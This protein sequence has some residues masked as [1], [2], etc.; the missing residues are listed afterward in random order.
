MAVDVVAVRVGIAGEIEP[1]HGH[2][3]AVA[4][5]LQQ[6]VDALFVSVGRFIGQES[7][8]FGDGGRQAG[9]VISDAAEERGFVG[10][11][12][13]LQAF[14]V[15]AGEDE[16]IDRIARPVRFFGGRRGGA[17]RRDEGPVALPFS[18]FVDPL[19]QRGDLLRSEGA[20]GGDGRHPIGAGGADPGEE[21]TIGGFTGD[22]YAVRKR[23]SIG[24]VEAEVRHP[25]RGI[26]TVAGEAF[27]GED[28][29]DFAVEVDGGE[30]GGGREQQGENSFSHE[31]ADAS[32]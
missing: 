3:F 11:G 5:R 8:E 24:G 13:V 12:G 26:R 14:L 20:A 19:F 2:A 10:F 23:A 17:L 31:G 4:G 6:G 32:F 30:G 29:A 28:G 25:F 27:V 18:P 16:I 21:M 22:D 1:L 15:E 9:Q 7:V